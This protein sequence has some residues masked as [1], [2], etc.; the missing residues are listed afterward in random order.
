[1]IF[2]KV[3]FVIVIL[4]TTSL[5]SINSIRNEEVTHKLIVTVSFDGN[6]YE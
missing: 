2:R 4:A 5:A 3:I 6:S 1:M